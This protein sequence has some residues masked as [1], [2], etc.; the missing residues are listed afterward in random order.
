[1]KEKKYSKDLINWPIY[2]NDYYS[3]LLEMNTDE[4]E[5][6]FKKAKEKSLQYLYYI[7]DE[8]GF[9]NYSLSDDEYDTKDNFPLIPY[10]RESRRINGMVTF[11]LNFIKKPY[12]QNHA[13]YRTGVLVGDYPVDHHHDAHPDRKNL[14]QLAFYPIPSY[15]LPVG[16][17]ISKKNPNFLVAEKSISVSNLVNGTTRLQPVVLQIGQI[18]GLIAS[19]SVKNDISTQEI[20]IRDLQ[21]I[22][23]ENGGYIQPYLDVEKDSPFFKVYQRIGSTGILRGTGINVGWSNQSWFYPENLVDLDLL[24]KDISSFVDMKQYPLNS[25]SI[26]DIKSWIEKI[27]DETVDLLGIW[28][29]L[30]LKN[31]DVNRKI[32]RGEL[33]VIIDHYINPFQKNINFKGELL[34]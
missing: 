2:G 25:T 19:E 14:P 16:S 27:S 28:S 17:I 31:Y 30:K 15:S 5:E 6:V 34:D 12:D 1:M 20:N 3:N 23:L 7:Q 4:R 24:Y 32:N 22:I 8:L 21:S 18:A 13:L 29:K 11:S 9:E 33:A 26:A 10:Y